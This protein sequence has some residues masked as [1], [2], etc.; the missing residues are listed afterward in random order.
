MNRS[1]KNNQGA[2]MHLG[3]ETQ[4]IQTNKA[5]KDLPQSPCGLT[6]H[7]TEEAIPYS[8]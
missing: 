6:A 7:Q 8:S 3:L 2:D 4:G 5:N 1:L